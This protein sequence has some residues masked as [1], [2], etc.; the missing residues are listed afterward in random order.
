MHLLLF[1]KK[2][3]IFLTFNLINKVIYTK[4]LNLL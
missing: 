1:F 4:L 2:D 3:T